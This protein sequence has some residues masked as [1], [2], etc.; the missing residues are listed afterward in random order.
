MA[1][2]VACSLATYEAMWLRNFL[3][4]L[5]LT[6]RVDDLAETLCDNTT[7][8]KFDKDPQLHRKIKHIKRWYIRADN[9]LNCLSSGNLNRPKSI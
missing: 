1:E 9:H 7:A 2:Y 5:N 8:I 6:P 4:D 3:Q